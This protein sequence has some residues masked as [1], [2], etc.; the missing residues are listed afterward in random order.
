MQIKA[1]EISQIIE[2][3]GAEV[4]FPTRT[5]HLAGNAEPDLDLAPSAHSEK[6]GRSGSRQT[7]APATS[8]ESEGAQ[9]D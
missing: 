1:E 8:G 9:D 7:A 4:A 5:L 6:Q 2:D 3:H